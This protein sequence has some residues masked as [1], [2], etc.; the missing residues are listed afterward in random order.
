MSNP[1]SGIISSEF[2]QV[3]NNAIDALLEDHALTLPCKLRYSGQQNPIFCNNCIY[4]PITK[5][6]ANLYNGSGPNPFADGTVCPVCMGNGI[7]D[8]ETTIVSKTFNLA[9]IFD[10]RYFVNTNKLINIPEGNIQT[11]CSIHLLPHIRGANDMIVD[12]NIQKY[13]QYIY[14]RDSDP[15]PAG[16]GDSKYIITNWKRK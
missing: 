1:F 5:L 10:S 15:E 8:S 7:T 6:S 9:V 4:D 2:K 12:T 16:L 11:L 3:F 13:G 14:Q